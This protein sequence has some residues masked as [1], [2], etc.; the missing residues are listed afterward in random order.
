MITWFKNQF[1]HKEVEAAKQA[2]IPVEEILNRFLALTEPGAMG[3]VVQPYW[4][5]GLDHPKAKG[6]FFS[7]KQVIKRFWQYRLLIL[8]PILPILYLKTV[9]RAFQLFGKFAQFFCTHAHLGAAIAHFAGRLVDLGDIFRS[10]ATFEACA[11]FSV[12]SLVPWK[13]CD[14]LLAISFG[15]SFL[16]NRCGDGGDDLIDLVYNLWDLIDIGDGA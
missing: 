3:L 8:Q 10:A 9:H 6:A 13:A 5:P 2:G 16:L 14:T 1:A 7:K 12:I 11:T 4:G 15:R